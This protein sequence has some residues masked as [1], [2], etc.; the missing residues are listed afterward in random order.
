ML[1]L[2]ES[3][4]TLLRVASSV[5]SDGTRHPQHTVGS[6]YGGIDFSWI[7]VKNSGTRGQC[8]LAQERCATCKFVDRGSTIGVGVSLLNH[9]VRRDVNLR[10]GRS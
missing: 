4:C 2:G 6:C 5:A 3:R 1:E 10:G 9:G 7:V 8:A